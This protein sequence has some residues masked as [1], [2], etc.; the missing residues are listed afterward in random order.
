MSVSSPFIHRPIATSLL[1]VAVM[2]GD[3]DRQQS[4]QSWLRLRSEQAPATSAPIVGWAVDPKRVLART[5]K[6]VSLS[7]MVRAR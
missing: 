6:D 4:T 2:L 1:G 5:F 7:G 3:V